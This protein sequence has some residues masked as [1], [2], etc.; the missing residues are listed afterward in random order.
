MT[1]IT[2]LAAIGLKA[3]EYKQT[4]DARKAAQADLNAAYKDWKESHCL[5]RVDPG[6]GAWEMMLDDTKAPYQALIAAQRIE[7]NAKDRLFRACRRA[8]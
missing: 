7:R 3:V 6:D 4:Q 2:D 5:E 8:A 1:S